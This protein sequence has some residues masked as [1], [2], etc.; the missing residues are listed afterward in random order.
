MIGASASALAVA[1]AF[2]VAAAVRRRRRAAM[3]QQVLR[4]WFEDGS[5]DELYSRRWFVPDGSAAQAALDEE[6]RT[7]F[8][9]LL[10]LAERGGLRGWCSTPHGALAFVVLLDQLSRHIHRGDR[11][12][13]EANDATALAATRAM[14]ARGWDASLDSVQLIFALMPLRHQPTEERLQE[15]L[16]RTAP[17]VAA[18][19]ANSQLLERF[20]RH[21]QLRLLH[22]QGRGDPNDILERHDCERECDQAGA[23]TSV[24]GRTVNAF[25]VEQG[26]V[27]AARLATRGS[28]GGG[29][30]PGN[31]ARGERP[32]RAGQRQRRTAARQRAAA[33]E[34]ATA[35]AAA[36]PRNTSA[37]AIPARGSG[38]V[39]GGGD[40]SEG[41]TAGATADATAEGEGGGDGDSGGGVEEPL[42]VSL[43]GGVDSMA[44]VHVLLALKALHGYRYTVCAVHIDYANRAESA[45]EAAYVRQWC[46]ARGVRVCVRVV[47]E[48]TRGATARDEY[49]KVSRA[50]RFGAY[51][52]A[53]AEWGGRGIFF[54]HHEGD[55]HENVISNVMKGA[56]LLNIAGIAAASRVNGVLIFRPMLRHPKSVVYSYAHSYGGTASDAPGRRRTPPL[57]QPFPVTMLSLSVPS[58]TSSVLP[59][60]EP[61]PCPRLCAPAWLMPRE[62]YHTLRIRHP[63]GR[64]AA[65]YATTSSRCCAKSTA[66]ASG[67]T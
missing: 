65:S 57:P 42:I 35:A 15:V 11:A 30:A 49:E 60:S 24:L 12:A 50:I 62:Q 17:R 23:P 64:R 5:F 20:R 3:A 40:S 8:G 4:F 61:P 31:T 33:F 9:H 58:L 43:S 45:A 13:I 38:C 34:G 28:G 25:L 39:D 7:L 63:S 54:G 21:T 55:L 10:A 1:A 66:R 46:E 41:A 6:V 27:P 14:V 32:P 44:L 51:R 53:V 16:E 22:L 26:L 18:C 36:P 59:H 2:T 52:A 47:S 56:Q 37:A 48:V 19:E 67:R 29:G